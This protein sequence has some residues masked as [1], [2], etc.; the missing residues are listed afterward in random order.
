MDTS[1]L[2]LASID[3]TTTYIFVTGVVIVI[4]LTIDLIRRLLTPGKN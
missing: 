1:T 4:L 2:Y 3:S